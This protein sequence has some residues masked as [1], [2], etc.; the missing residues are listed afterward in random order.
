MYCETTTTL[1]P[2]HTELGKTFFNT[3]SQAQLHSTPAI[4]LPL[5]CYPHRL[6]Y[7]SFQWGNKWC[8]VSGS[9]CTVFPLLYCSPLSCVTVTSSVGP[10][11]YML[12]VC[13]SPTRRNFC[14]SDLG[15]PS[16]ALS[17]CVHIS[18]SFFLCFTPSFSLTL[19]LLILFFFF[20][21][22]F[23]LCSFTLSILPPPWC[24]CPCSSHKNLNTLKILKQRNKQA[25]IYIYTYIYVYS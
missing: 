21:L 13:H 2:P 16:F 6:Q 7:L 4:F 25:N 11:V 5:L 12:V 18:P 1:P 14:F 3:L 17:F 24:F 19:I 10:P 8:R 20:S 22:Y 23:S 9:E 15:I